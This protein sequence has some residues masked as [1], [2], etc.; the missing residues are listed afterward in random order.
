MAQSRKRKYAHSDASEESAYTNKQPRLS[1]LDE[2]K[3][4]KTKLENCRTI[5]FDGNSI[6]PDA[7]PVSFLV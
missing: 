1:V 2:G 5:K 7:N 6:E 3:G 4:P